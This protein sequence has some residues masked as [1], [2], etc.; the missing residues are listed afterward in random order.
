MGAS[1]AVKAQYAIKSVVRDNFLC[2]KEVVRLIANERIPIESQ[3]A[4]RRK[5][6]ARTLRAARKRIPF[7]HDMCAEIT[8]QNAEQILRAYPVVSRQDL[9]N[10]TELFYPAGGRAYPWTIVGETSGTTGV[11][12]RVVRDLRSVL[13]ERAFL[14]RHWSWSGFTQGMRRATLRGDAVVPAQRRTPPFWQYNMFDN[15]LILSSAH[16][17]PNTADLFIAQLESWQPYL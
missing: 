17:N 15:Q 8:E 4:L 12:L 11:P 10:G 3:T 7:Y 2:Q 14:R 9:L 13:M 16:L 1:L 5:L 6:L